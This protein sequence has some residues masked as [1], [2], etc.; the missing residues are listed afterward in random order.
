MFLNKEQR[1]GKVKHFQSRGNYFRFYNQQPGWKKYLKR[2]FKIR[3]LTEKYTL[4]YQQET[5]QTKN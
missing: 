5:N 1:K 3:Q 2:D 4:N